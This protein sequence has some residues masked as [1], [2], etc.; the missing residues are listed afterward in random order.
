MVTLSM[1]HQR[2]DPDI[3]RKGA[4]LG[5]R[6]CTHL[7]NG[8]PEM[9]HRHRNSLWTAL[10]DDRLSTLVI[11]DGH[12]LP[13][14]MLRV[15]LRAKGRRRTIATSDMSFLAGMPPG[16]YTVADQPVVLEN[17]GRLHRE[18]AWQLAGSSCDL[19]DCM[20]VIAGIGEFD[21]DEMMDVGRR[22]ALSLLATP[23][24]DRAHSGGILRYDGR[25]FAP[26]ENPSHP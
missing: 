19:L 1:G 17:D 5:I 23:F 16:R 2:D 14:D 12:H 21:G 7:G 25:R 10:A 3:L 8:L 9:L 20:N 6:F 24:R 4:D 13:I 26:A 18:G 22:N 11:C 15:I